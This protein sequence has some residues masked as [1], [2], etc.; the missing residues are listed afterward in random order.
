MTNE[1]HVKG[2]T[3]KTPGLGRVDIA[4]T[5]ENFGEIHQFDAV[6]GSAGARNQLG[7]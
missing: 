2:L 7:V 1:L 6:L 3:I 4:E 5:T